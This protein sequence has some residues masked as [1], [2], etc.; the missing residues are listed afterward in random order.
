MKGQVA[1]TCGRKMLNINA[2]EPKLLVYSE[3]ISNTFKRVEVHFSL[4]HTG[5]R[6]RMCVGDG[7]RL[8]VPDKEGME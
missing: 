5:I 1:D 3:N 4:H 2:N 7:W 6:L 8:Y